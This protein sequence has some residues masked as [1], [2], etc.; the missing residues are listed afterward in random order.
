MQMLLKRFKKE[1][2]GFTLIEL[3]AVIVILAVIAVIAVPLIGNI[4]SKNKENADLATARQIYD[5]ARLYNVAENNGTMAT[6]TIAA[7][8]STDFLEKKIYLPSSKAE[9]TAGAVTFTTGELTSVSLVTSATSV[10]STLVDETKNKTS[11]DRF[12]FGTTVLKQ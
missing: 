9:I 6:V 11:A 3:L 8:Q 5:A 1:E 10:P 7:L 2:K 12:Y 4:I